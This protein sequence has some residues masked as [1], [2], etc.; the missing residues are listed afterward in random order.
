M[1]AKGFGLAAMRAVCHCR[2]DIIRHERCMR[3]LIAGGGGEPFGPPDR[4]GGKASPGAAPKVRVCVVAGTPA[5]QR[6]L[7]RSSNSVIM[8]QG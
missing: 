7:T 4:S 2:E 6:W 5:L 1:R 8:Q 3:V